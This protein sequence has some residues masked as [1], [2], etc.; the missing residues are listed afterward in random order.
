MD[1][2]LKINN[3]Y[4]SIKDRTSFIKNAIDENTK[5]I[6]K[7]KNNTDNLIEKENND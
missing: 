3:L 7:N 5:I 4:K 1:S 6:E 2:I